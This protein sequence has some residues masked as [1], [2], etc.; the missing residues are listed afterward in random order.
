MSLPKE[1]TCVECKTINLVDVNSMSKRPSWRSKKPDFVHCPCKQ[2]R[3]WSM[4]K[5]ERVEVYKYGA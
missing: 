3:K 1:F 4:V 2:C 5:Y